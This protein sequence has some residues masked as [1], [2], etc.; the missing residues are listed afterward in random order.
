MLRKRRAINCEKSKLK[1]FAQ[2]SHTIHNA[3][4]GEG[5]YHL[6]KELSTSRP[7]HSTHLTMKAAKG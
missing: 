6:L 7:L 3:Y 4:E 1:L 5:S 2:T